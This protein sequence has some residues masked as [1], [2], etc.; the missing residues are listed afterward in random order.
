MEVYNKLGGKEK[1]FEILMNHGFSIE[2]IRVM[3][4]RKS[5]PKKAII[6]IM[7]DRKDI[8]WDPSD[9]GGKQ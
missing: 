6:L 1:V 9:F 2:Q 5:F 4:C 8:N 7:N 3:D